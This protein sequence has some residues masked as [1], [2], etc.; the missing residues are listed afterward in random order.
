[1]SFEFSPIFLASASSRFLDDAARLGPPHLLDIIDELMCVEGEE[2]WVASS[3]PGC[4][5]HCNSPK[6]SINRIV[7]SP[8]L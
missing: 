4:S 2:D 7:I 5:Y 8:S 3:F 6:D 1:M